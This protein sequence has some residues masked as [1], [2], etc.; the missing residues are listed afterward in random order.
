MP[1][2]GGR[3]GGRGSRLGGGSGRAFIDLPEQ[4][5]DRNGFAILGDD[6]AE[7]TCRRRGDLDCH[8]V[9]FEFDQRF[10]H[11]NGVAGFLEPA[12]DGG[13]GHGLAER[14]NANFS[15][16]LFPLAS[17]PGLSRPSKP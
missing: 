5:A 10:V 16:G 4:P 12:A 2:R 7:R 13:L 11:R 3:L 9:G 6:F 1:S 14:R 8:L 17:W 15:H